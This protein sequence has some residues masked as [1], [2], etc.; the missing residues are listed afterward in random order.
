MAPM[1]PGGL[2]RCGCGGKTQLASKTRSSRG[3]VKGKPVDYIRGHNNLRYTPGYEERDCGYETPCWF[4]TGC[5]SSSGH[6]MAPGS[7]RVYCDVYEAEYGPVGDLHVHHLCETP[8]CVRPDHM[9]AVTKGRHRSIHNKRVL[10]PELAEEIRRAAGSH[11]AIAARLGISK[12]TV[13]RV[14]AGTSFL[15][16]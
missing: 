10:T 4:W 12:T 6:A 7:K 13:T 11:R 5:L 14:R 15:D 3:W 9:E 1:N 8:Q 2:C 16:H